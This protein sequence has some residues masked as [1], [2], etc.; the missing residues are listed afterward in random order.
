MNPGDVFETFVRG[1]SKL[2]FVVGRSGPI[3]KKID[4][5]SLS[6]LCW[7]SKAKA[8]R[9]LEEKLTP[10]TASGFTLQNLDFE[11]YIEPRQSVKWIEEKEKVKLEIF[12]REPKST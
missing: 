7:E 6:V 12:G 10:K 1:E 4:E 11:E 2:W 8:N 3:V 5:Q 9:F